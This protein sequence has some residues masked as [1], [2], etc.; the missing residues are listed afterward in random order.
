YDGTNYVGWQV[1]PNGTS[2]QSIVTRA[3]EQLTGAA[4]KLIAA[5]RTDA[6]VHA[7]GQVANF[8]TESTIPCEKMRAGLQSFLP[9]DVV[10]RDV[11]DVPDD[12]HATY[13][14]CKKRYRYVI[15]NSRVSDPFTRRYAWRIGAKLDRAAMQDAAQTLLG[16]HDFRCFESQF[17]NKATS[18]RTVLEAT[19]ARTNVWRLWDADENCSA[20]A[21]GA[22]DYIWFDIVADGFLYNMVRAI[23]GTLVKVG[24]GKW[25]AADVRGIIEQQDRG[26]AGETAPPQGLYLVRVDY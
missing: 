15:H 2:V 13:S 3:S 5:G 11:A 10:V 18:V 6:G 24:L 19:V 26:L 1:Q 23:V 20:P 16:T 4:V 25:T 14:A 9:E 22:G 12:F 7:L 21:S 8:H 17:P